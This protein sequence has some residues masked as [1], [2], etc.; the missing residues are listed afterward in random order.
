[1]FYIS[2][3]FYH[4][5]H[6]VPLMYPTSLLFYSVT[7]SHIIFIIFFSPAHINDIPIKKLHNP[8]TTVFLI[9]PGE[10]FAFGKNIARALYL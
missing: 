9:D 5:F 6:H 4:Q 1:M 3:D 2:A 7:L 10:Y 8:S